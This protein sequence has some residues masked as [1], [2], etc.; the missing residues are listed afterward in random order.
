[1]QYFRKS[2][3]GSEVTSLQN[4][5]ENE[6]KGSMIIQLFFHLFHLSFQ[7]LLQQRVKWLY[8]LHTL[9]F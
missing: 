9:Y 2:F 5:V 4:S 1:M 7:F 6:V 8:Q 3:D